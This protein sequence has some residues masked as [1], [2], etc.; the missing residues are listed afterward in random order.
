MNQDDQASETQTAPDL[1]GDSIRHIV[2]NLGGYDALNLAAVGRHFRTSISTMYPSEYSRL[3]TK[4]PVCIFGSL[5]QESTRTK[6]DM[7]KIFEYFMRVKSEQWVAEKLQTR[8]NKLSG[9]LKSMTP[10]QVALYTKNAPFLLTIVAKIQRSEIL[11]SICSQVGIQRRLELL[12]LPR[13]YIVKLGSLDKVRVAVL[14]DDS[15]D[16]LLNSSTFSGMTRFEEMKTFL[17]R[18]QWFLKTINPQRPLDL[19]LMKRDVVEADIRDIRRI[20]KVFR[21]TRPV[22]DRP[23]IERLSD[24]IN[25]YKSETKHHIVELIV[26]TSGLPSDG[27][28]RRLLEVLNSRGHVTDRLPIVIKSF[29]DSFASH[30]NIEQSPNVYFVKDYALEK[31]RDRTYRD[32]VA[33]TLL[34]GFTQKIDD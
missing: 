29:N 23:W 10:I 24:L 4:D 25:F 21:N 32:H 31:H 14:V 20:I 28:Q 13:E 27:S 33:D 26:L 19:H 7:E 22:G 1:D 15:I 17:L 30:S 2:S 8:C 16:M 5:A 3:T 18:I 6:E 11:L 9:S 34:R 12:H